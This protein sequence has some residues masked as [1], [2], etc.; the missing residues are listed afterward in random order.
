M[1]HIKLKFK[2]SWCYNMGYTGLISAR[3]RHAGD[4]L[5][6]VGHEPQNGPLN[7]LIPATAEKG[8]SGGGG[9]ASQARKCSTGPQH[10]VQTTRMGPSVWGLPTVGRKSCRIGGPCVGKV[11]L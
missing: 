4:K 1:E 6:G 5:Y 10:V 11:A 3:W 2:N 8:D 9:G 7:E